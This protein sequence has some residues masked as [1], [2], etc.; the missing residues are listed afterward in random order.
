M[1]LALASNNPHKA[2]EL[3]RIFTHHQI[4]TAPD[5]GL[6]FHHEE[7]G[8]TYLANA[9]GK[10][11]ALREELTAVGRDDLSVIADDSGLSVPALGGAP[12]IHSA[13][14]AP[15]E[16]ADGWTDRDRYLYLLRRMRAVEDRSAFFVC[17]MVLLLGEYRFF[18]AQETLSG[19]I[20]EEPEGS[21]GF[22]YDPVFTVTGR[23]LTV[24]QL[25]DA[26]KDALS[27]R[28]RAGR[29]MLELLRGL[30]EEMR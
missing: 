11:R 3:G 25:S 6:G 13:R 28:G 2:L 20:A 14:F 16:G 1:K 10:A 7:T 30:E 26:E 4:V 12:G 24:A 5:L 27:H 29:R 21:G 9:L 17:C 22:G 15:P 8:S 18:A 23:E 19:S